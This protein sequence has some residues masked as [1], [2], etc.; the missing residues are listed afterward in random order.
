MGCASTDKGK[1]TWVAWSHQ[2]NISYQSQAI[3]FLRGGNRVSVSQTNL[4][5]RGQQVWRVMWRSMTHLSHRSSAVKSRHYPFSGMK[6]KWNERKRY[7]DYGWI[8]RVGRWKSDV[9][10]REKERKKS[11]DMSQL[12]EQRAGKRKEC[13]QGQ[14]S[15]LVGTWPRADDIFAF[16]LIILSVVWIH[17]WIAKK[18][19]TSK[20]FKHFKTM[21]LLNDM[22]AVILVKNFLKINDI[23]VS[24]DSQTT[25]YFQNF[26]K[27]KILFILWNSNSPRIKP[28]GTP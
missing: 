12:E 24:A 25:F 23:I 2:R 19:K 10:K 6:W 11:E 13:V 22:I 28:C 4:G 3:L 8:W 18:N 27:I 21:R 16:L 14:Q 26:I 7:Q 15:L 17:L 5:D 20:T 9:K 1:R